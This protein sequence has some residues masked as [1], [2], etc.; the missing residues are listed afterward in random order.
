MST[1]PIQRPPSYVDRHEIRPGKA[2]KEATLGLL[3]R[4]DK[5]MQEYDLS[6]SKSTVR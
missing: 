3:E 5:T 2:G 4:M 6:R 1:T